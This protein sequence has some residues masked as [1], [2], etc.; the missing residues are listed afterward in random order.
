MSDNASDA[1]ADHSDMNRIPHRRYPCV[2]CPWR[3]DVTPGQFPLEAFEALTRTVGGPGREVS[4]TAPMFACHKSPEGDEAACAGWL[5]VAGWDHFGIR[6]AVIEGR[7]DPSVLRPGHNWP[8]LHASYTEMV[9]KKAARTPKSTPAVTE[10]SDP[11][12]V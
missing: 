7:I 2:E 6:R 10:T 11:D 12:M 4:D 9:T 3:R 5:A 8:P 1:A